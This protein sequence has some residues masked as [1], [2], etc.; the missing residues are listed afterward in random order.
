[1]EI[2]GIDGDFTQDFYKFSQVMCNIRR[3]QDEAYRADEMEFLLLGS[4]RLF[5]LFL[6]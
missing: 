5:G 3:R 1:M 6:K 4:W 2:N